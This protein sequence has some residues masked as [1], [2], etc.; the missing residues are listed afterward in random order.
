M[1]KDKIIQVTIKIPREVWDNYIIPAVDRL[2][3]RSQAEHPEWAPR[4][5]RHQPSITDSVIEA[6]KG[7]S[8]R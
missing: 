2:W 3:A 7:G 1:A 6:I 5:P 4:D 8:R